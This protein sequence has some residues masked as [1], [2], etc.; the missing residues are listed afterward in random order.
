MTFFFRPPFAVAGLALLC[1]S[2]SG[3]FDSEPAERKAFMEFLQVHVLDKPGVHVP[4]P[5][6]QE[7]KSFGPYAKHCAVITDFTADPGMVAITKDMAEAIQIGA[8]RSI[9]ELMDRRQDV[10]TVG[11]TMAKLRTAMEKKIGETEAA[12]AALQQPADLKAVY[13]AA[14]DRDV[15]DPARAFHTALPI[16]EETFV[17]IQRLVDFLDA[18]QG[19]VIFSGSTV[20]TSDPKIRAELTTIL[21]VM[22][23]KSQ[24]I[25]DLQRRIRLVLTGY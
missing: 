3:C 17:A 24:Q 15:S 13:S 1:L 16:V 5:T 2:I 14:F 18:H 7:I 6:D 19:V 10:K 21:N 11:E 8:P 25:Q 22:N 20:Q 4:K 9:K 23:A 12:R